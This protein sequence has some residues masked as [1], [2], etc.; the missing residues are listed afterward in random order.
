[1]PRFT[2]GQRSQRS[3]ALETA[4]LVWSIWRWLPA[5]QKMKALILARRHG[6]WLVSGAL[7][8]RRAR[9]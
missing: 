4:A 7:R 6:P 2:R 5:E 3:R 8:H 1:M 9:D